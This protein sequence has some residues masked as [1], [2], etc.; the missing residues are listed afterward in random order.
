ML[1]SKPVSLEHF[2]NP[3]GVELPNLHSLLK[4]LD[5]ILGLPHTGLGSCDS[6]HE[7]ESD[8]G[9]DGGTRIQNMTMRY[10]QLLMDCKRQ[11]VAKCESGRP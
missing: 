10:T 9:T 3:R 1:P 5:M 8:D 7:P 2:S 11:A 4:F 6:R